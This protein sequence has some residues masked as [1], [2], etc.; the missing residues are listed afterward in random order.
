MPTKW[1]E[2]VG[3]SAD[4]CGV[5]LSRFECIGGTGVPNQFRG[6][7]VRWGDLWQKV[8]GGYPYVL[9]TSNAA[10]GPDTMHSPTLDMSFWNFLIACGQ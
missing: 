7:G 9:K 4:F 2:T 5:R 3:W 10:H 1:P 6:V 8:D